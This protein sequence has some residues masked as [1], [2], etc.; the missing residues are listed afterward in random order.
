MTARAVLLKVHLWLGLSAAI[1]LVVL[2]LTG[3]IVAFEN[4]IDRWLHPD[5]YCVEARPQALPEANLVDI[6]QQKVAP[7][8][9]AALHIFRQRDRAQVMQLTDRSTVFVD[10]YDGRILGRQRGPSATQRM[11]GYIHQIHTHLVP[12]PRSTAAAAKYGQMIVRIA[13]FMLCF[14]VPIGVIL[15][16]RG[17]RAALNWRTSWFRRCFDAHQTIGI[18][19]ALFLFIAA[20]TGVLVG[21][22]NVFF[23]LTHSRGPSRFPQLQSAVSDGAA[24]L[25]ADRAEDIARGVMPG[26]TVTDLQLPLN[27]RGVFL[28]V[29]RVRE[30]TSEAAHSYVFVDQ[31][32]GN[33]LHTVNFLTESPGYRAI[34]FNRSIHTG[35]VW[36]TTGHIIVSVSSLLLVVMVVT[37]LGIW[38]G[39]RL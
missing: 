33:V 1:F 16:W 37:G 19:A 29:L 38:S 5:L 36:G 13:G 34:R 6:V 22:E 4:D 7:A 28:V 14:L 23:S 2:G 12:D 32:S 25:S 27:P 17:K 31:Y 20:L 3:S 10:P 15:W 8:R 26:T 30:E 11:V 39:R 9:V 35:D 21:Q 18:Y 24:P